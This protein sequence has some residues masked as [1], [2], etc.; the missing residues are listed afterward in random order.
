MRRSLPHELR[1][2]TTAGKGK[3]SPDTR[4]QVRSALDGPPSAT[5]EAM[6]GLQKMP[7]SPTPHAEKNKQDITAAP[8]IGQNSEREQDSRGLELR[9][10]VK[11]KFV[12]LGPAWRDDRPLTI[13]VAAQRECAIPDSSAAAAERAG[14]RAPRFRPRTRC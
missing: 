11:A 2:Y 4:V 5:Y 9:H 8:N 3:P 1:A 10:L 6:T 14:P 13:W 12:R 7:P